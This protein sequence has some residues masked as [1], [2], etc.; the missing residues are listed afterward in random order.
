MKV[1]NLKLAI[2]KDFFIIRISALI[3]NQRAL[4]LID[5]FFPLL[6]C[7][8][9]EASFSCLNVSKPQSLVLVVMDISISLRV[10]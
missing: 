5:S 9:A 10:V 8:S 3:I 6:I 7:K 2:L 4:C 1:I